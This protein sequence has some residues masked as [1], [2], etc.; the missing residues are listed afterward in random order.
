MAG[1]RDPKALEQLERFRR[2][3]ALPAQRA[4]EAGWP[5]NNPSS[6]L[7]QLRRAAEVARLTEQQNQEMQA[8]GQ[9]LASR[10]TEELELATARIR[11]AEARA[12]AAEVRAAN[13]EARVAEIQQWLDSVHDVI[14]EEFGPNLLEE[15]PGERDRSRP[16]LLPP[17]PPSS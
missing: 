8:R 5:Q 17:R 15:G 7:E 14:V 3:T 11:A 9:E 10:V 6:A 1:P 13:A 4:D 12:H 2:R 16:S